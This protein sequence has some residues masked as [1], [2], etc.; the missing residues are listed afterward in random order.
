M[1]MRKMNK[2]GIFFTF[3]AIGLV[4]LLVYSFVIHTGY[5]YRDS[6]FVIETRV[7]TI[8][9]FI[10]DVE[11]DINRGLYISSFRSLLA[12][13]DYIIENDSF[14]SD[15]NS[16]FEEALINETIFNQ[17]NSLIENASFSYWVMK[18]QGEASKID[19][20]L[21]MEAT[22]I[23]INQ[24]D[25]WS[26]NVEMDII[27]NV[28]DRKKTASWMKS[29]HI[30]TSID[31]EGF[32]DPIYSLNTFGKVTNRIEQANQTNFND[33]DVLKGHIE[34]SYYITSN[35]SPSFLM[36]LEGNLSN[37][38]MGIESIVNLDKLKIQGLSLK[39]ASVVDYIY[40][41]NL[42]ISSCSINET[43]NQ[44]GYDWFRLDDS[45]NYHLDI[46]KVNCI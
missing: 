6:M 35:K 31:I 11:V 14:I 18:I 1:A 3:V 37:S 30:M 8:G 40:F 42:S 24:T 23:T 19:I 25:P 13:Q 45:D 5:I 16:V 4:S 36:R 21:D 34:N 20:I 39:T 2:R 33:I 26:V 9:N 27:I 17:S 15:V 7:S 46:Y 41:S 29:K 22:N 32:E 38:S 28:T 43:F 44:T 10:K 12:I